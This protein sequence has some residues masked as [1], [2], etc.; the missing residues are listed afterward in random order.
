MVLVFFR[1]LEC[2]DTGLRVLKPD[3][4]A[5]TKQFVTLLSFG[6]QLIMSML[7]PAD[8]TSTGPELDILAATRSTPLCVVLEF[9]LCVTAVHVDSPS[10]Q[11]QLDIVAERFLDSKK[12]KRLQYH[13]SQ[14]Q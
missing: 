9:S 5:A 12:I 13:C 10:Q 8:D 4:N 7:T 14:V 3:S 1:N 11:W 6:S 2:F